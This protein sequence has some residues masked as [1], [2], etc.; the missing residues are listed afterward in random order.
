MRNLLLVLGVVG[1]SACHAV[2]VNHEDSPAQVPVPVQAD[3]VASWLEEWHQVRVLPED[4]LVQSFNNRQLAFERSANPA[5]RLRLALLLAEGPQPVRNQA[6]ALELL[7]ELDAEQASDSEKALA[8]LLV[9]V[10]EEQKWLINKMATLNGDLKE[11]RMHVEELERQLRELTTIEQNI[12]ER[13]I[14]DSQ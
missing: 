8:A 10:L 5:T 7:G 9:Q 2:T 12:Q 4:Q 11:S 6:R 13:E 1:M 3:G 14:P